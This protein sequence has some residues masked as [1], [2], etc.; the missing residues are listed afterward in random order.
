[1]KKL[2]PTTLM[3]A[4]MFGAGLQPADAGQSGSRAE[5]NPD[6][7]TEGFLS[8][9]PD[10][11]WRREGLRSY[12][13]GDH[14]SALTQF[15]RAARY[16]D[17]PSQLLVAEMYWT[18]AGV[19]RDRAM[20]YIWMD[21]AA[22]RMYHDFVVFRERYWNQMTEAERADAIERGEEVYA[23]YGDDVAKPRL[24]QILRRERR[25]VT[26]SRV[27]FVGNLTITPNTGPLAGTG[28]TISGDQYYADEYWVP[29]KYF[30]MQDNIW[31]ETLRGRVQVGDVETVRD[32][33]D[34]D[35]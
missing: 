4:V 21:L 13:R 23:E 34:Q 8:A 20:G 1:M 24:A 18:G 9:H 16:A 35:E 5:I 29:E 2:I 28:M 31:G 19:P 14:A 26:G 30:E 33:P 25:N 12:E 17:K 27:G 22:E 11:R 32:H 7:L 15:K 10:L 3:I 6:I